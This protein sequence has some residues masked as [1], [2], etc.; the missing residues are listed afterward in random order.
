M[1]VVVTEAQWAV[2]E[3]E[4]G[5]QGSVIIVVVEAFE[6]TLIIHVSCLHSF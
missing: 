3:E 1:A 5:I 2:P 4:E 6:G